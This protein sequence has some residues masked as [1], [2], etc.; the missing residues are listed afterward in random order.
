M[1]GYPGS[2]SFPIIMPFAEEGVSFLDQN[3]A[4]SWQTCFTLPPLSA[5]SLLVTSSVLCFFRSKQK[6]LSCGCHTEAD[7]KDLPTS[8]ETDLLRPPAHLQSQPQTPKAPPRQP[9]FVFLGR[10]PK[11]IPLLSHIILHKQDFLPPPPPIRIYSAPAFNISVANHCPRPQESRIHTRGMPPHPPG[12]DCRS[13]RHCLS[14]K[15]WGVPVHHCCGRGSPAHARVTHWGARTD[16]CVTLLGR[17]SRPRDAG[18][19]S[20]RGGL[21]TSQGRASS[22]LCGEITGN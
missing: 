19:E 14:G 4:S 1:Y 12:V 15:G 5:P 16:Q 3:E 8:L 9:P 6:P 18:W 7:A 13:P 11:A 2:S 21:E 10:F 20:I 17:E 22:Q